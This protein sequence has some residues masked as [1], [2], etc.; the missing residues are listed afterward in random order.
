VKKDKAVVLLSGGLD[1]ATT[2]G[3]A[4][5]EGFEAYCLSFRYGQ[6]HVREIES[7]QK[8]AKSM[9]SSHHLVVDIDLGSIGHSALTDMQID[10]PRDRI[11]SG[12]E[13]D[14][15]VTYVPARNTIFLSYALG[16]AESLGAFAVFIGVNSAD[17]SGYPD[18][19]PEYIEAYERMANLAT[20]AAVRKKGHF[21]IHTPIV[22]MSK[23][24]IIKTGTSLGVDFGL[25]HSCYDPQAD[26]VSCGHCD[27]CKI[28]LKGFEEANL[29]DPLKYAE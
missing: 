22:N 24:Q 7:A 16:W 1:S 14:I 25:T 6:R 10:V 17:Y 12:D 28:R 13:N 3:I 20:K 26:G 5:E 15:P 21:K 11:S 19:R 27:S 29:K 4:I 9:K 2:L 23:A 18:C 8:V